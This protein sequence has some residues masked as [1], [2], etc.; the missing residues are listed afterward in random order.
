MGI[1][2]KSTFSELLEGGSAAIS[3]ARPKYR[4]ALVA[5]SKRPPAKPAGKATPA[6]DFKHL[7]PSNDPH[8]FH[9]AA[10]AARAARAAEATKR[11]TDDADREL[12]R[13]IVAAGKARRGEK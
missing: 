7:A 6:M 10:D 11:A 4:A 2:M 13:R 8:G 9:R 3:K 5:T 1:D 12:A